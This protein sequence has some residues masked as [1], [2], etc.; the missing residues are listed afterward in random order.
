MIGLRFRNHTGFV[1]SP[2]P[3]AVLEL[4]ILLQTP[5]L[6]HLLEDD[7]DLDGAPGETCAA[8]PRHRHDLREELP[9]LVG[10]RGPINHDQHVQIA[11]STQ[12]THHRRSIVIDANDA[13]PESPKYTPNH[14][15][16]LPRIGAVHHATLP[17]PTD[18]TTKRRA[19]PRN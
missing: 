5:W 19:A 9:T 16:E 17:Q 1:V 15:I 11:Q 4:A 3:L 6:D 12:S 10:G 18:Q 14:G 8:I 13:A 7:R 2:Q